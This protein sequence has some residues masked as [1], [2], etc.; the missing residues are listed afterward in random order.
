MKAGTSSIYYNLREV[1]GVGLSRAKEPNFFL[2]P[3]RPDQLAEYEKSFGEGNIKVDVSPSYS[4]RLHYPDTA[5]RIFEY[6]PEA[7]IIYLLRDPVERIVS[8]LRHDLFRSRFRRSRLDEHLKANPDYIETSKY[9]Y[10]AEPYLELFGSNVLLLSF[11]KLFQG[12]DTEK[13]KLKDFLGLENAL[14]TLKGYNQSDSRTRYKIPF[15]DRLRESLGN[16]RLFTGYKLFWYFLQIKVDKPE[17]A[18]HS[19]QWIM[20]ELGQDMECLENELGFD[21]SL[22][23]KAY[24]SP[25]S[26]S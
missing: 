2:H 25:R 9:Y 8:H 22:W 20:D 14:L 11:E 10:Q 7:R 23:Q 19:I 6:N 15:H 5:R 4:K 17:L 12:S 13:Q 3:G 26:S 16:G 24:P 21:T 18:A 1:E